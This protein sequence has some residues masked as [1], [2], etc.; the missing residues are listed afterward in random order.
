MDGDRWSLLSTFYNAWLAADSDERR[1]LRDRLASEQPEL[2]VEAEKILA[3]STSLDGFLEVP[4]FVVEA[5]ELAGELPALDAGTAVGPY[6]I[7]GLLAHGGMGD[8]Y[9]ATDV[10]LGRDVA[11]KVLAE[12]APYDPRRMDRFEQEARTTASLDHPNVV[13][14]FDVG[15]FDGRPYLVAELLVGETLR[16]RLAQAPIAPPE[17]CRIAADVTRGL[18]AAHAAG[19][20]HRDLKPE[21]IFLTRAG[22]TKI[23]DFGI[24][25]LVEQ[26]V[27]PDAS[28]TFTGVLLGTAGYLAPEQIQGHTVDGRAD[29]FALGAILFEMIT[30]RRAFARETTIDTL[31][32]IVH[33]S[34]PDVLSSRTDLPPGV[35]LIVSRLLEKSPDARFQSAADLSWMLERLDAMPLKSASARTSAVRPALEGLRG[36]TF[37]WIAAIAAASALGAWTIWPVPVVPA[38]MLDP[39]QFTWPLPEHMTLASEP[40]VSPDGR[41]IAFVGEE[42]SGRRLY[43]RD[44]SSLD[45]SAVPGTEGAKQPFWSPGGDAVGFFARGRLLRVTLQGGA[46]VDLAPAPDARGGTWSRSGVIVFQPFFRDNALAQIPAN[47]GEVRPATLFDVTGDETSHKWPVFLPDGVHF[48]YQVLSVDES[49]RGI[50]VGSLADPPS[51][52]AAPLFRTESGAIYVTLRGTGALMSIDGG[53]IH[54]RPF[55]PKRLG[56]T[57]DPRTIGLAAASATLHYPA[58]LGVS[59]G[60]LA[61]ARTI[62]PAGVHIASVAIDGRNLVVS[63]SREVA[64]SP[65]VSPDGSR[66]A[67]SRA[68]PLSGDSDIWIDDLVRETPLRVTTSR[69]HDVSPVWSPDGRQLAYRS[70]P[71]GASNLSIASADGTG[72]VRVMRCPGEPCLPTDWSPDGQRLL[73]NVGHD[74]W[75]LRVG[76]EGTAQPLLGGPWEER[77]ARFSP[78]GQW[79]GYVSNESGRSEVYARRLT[80]TPRRFVVSRGGDQ[81]VWRRDGRTLFY[82]SLDGD[83][84]GV[85]IGSDVD[86]GVTLGA[87]EKLPIPR[88]AARHLGTVYD[89]SSDAR[90]IHFA[91]PGDPPRPR[92]IGVVLNW[93]G[94]VK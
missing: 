25:K 53:E 74:V 44:L 49:R 89:V 69:D 31:Y 57:G 32:A 24:A 7:A 26:D 42:D 16:S 90:R 86:G 15:T 59:S 5:Q 14:I 1:R 84:H 87:P 58:M 66:L 39:A 60:V 92:E 13:R 46:P 33:E 83:L 45:A 81:P 79:V 62:I 22:V 85:A 47:G 38:T 94:L 80:G 36:R 29:L 56:I 12:S 23:L 78:D 77:D 50:Y 73:M 70:G 28:A 3:G 18:V 82:V 63:P 30:G 91:H 48:L 10:R 65:R 27:A 88:F 2:I 71:I 93:A 61:F 67:R 54:V 19:L 34:P 75:S 6:R 21:N 17:A 40:V 43:V 64:G 8:V 51:R 55:N 4:A 41:R 9:R 11:V 20:V 35:P 72:V 52:P 76:D 37:L 68:D